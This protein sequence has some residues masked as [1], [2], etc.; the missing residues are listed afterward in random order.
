MEKGEENK[1]PIPVIC[2]ATMVTLSRG[3]ILWMI[4]ARPASKRETQTNAIVSVAIKTLNVPSGGTRWQGSGS[5]LQVHVLNLLTR[6]P[7][8]RHCVSKFEV[9]K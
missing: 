6:P 1:T 8:F 5:A 2:A 4:L 3:M 7:V 9:K